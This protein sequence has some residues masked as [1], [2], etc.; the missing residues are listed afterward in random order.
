VEAAHDEAMIA[1]FDTCNVNSSNCLD[2]GGF[3]IYRMRKTAS[4]VRDVK[5]A[6]LALKLRF[7][8]NKNI[9]NFYSH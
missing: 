4:C 3:N 2:Y 8:K 5:G 6:H 7:P 9:Q 1:G